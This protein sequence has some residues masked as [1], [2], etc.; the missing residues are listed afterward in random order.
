MI[1]LKV[2]QAEKK[3]DKACRKAKAIEEKE[4]LAILK[5][6]EPNQEKIRAAWDKARRALAR[7][8]EVKS[9]EDK[10]IGVNHLIEKFLIIGL[11]VTTLIMLAVIGITIALVMKV[12]AL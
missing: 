10:G 8:E 5:G 9:K 7:L 1:S 11:V 12:S 4:N 6:W 3:A 2:A